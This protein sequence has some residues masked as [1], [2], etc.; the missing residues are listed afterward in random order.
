M[1]R[2]VGQNLAAPG[3]TE[4]DGSDMIALPGFVDTHTHLVVDADARPLRR[5]A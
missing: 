1:I 3:A 4:I 5:H 2:A